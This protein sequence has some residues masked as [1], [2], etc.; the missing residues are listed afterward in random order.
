MLSVVA[1]L[2]LQKQRLV[3]GVVLRAF[4]AGIRSLPENLGFHFKDSSWPLWS[5][6]KA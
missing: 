1:L 4:T 2:S 3:V 6:R 5:S